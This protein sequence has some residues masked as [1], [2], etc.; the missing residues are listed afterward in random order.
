NHCRAN[1]LRGMLFSVTSGKGFGQSRIITASSYGVYMDLTFDV[2]FSEALDA[3][4]VWNIQ[5]SRLPSLDATLRPSVL[6]SN[7]AVLDATAI[8]T[9]AAIW[10]AATRTLTRPN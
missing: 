9:A 3:T 2:A 10:S 1:A 4:T 5:P 6:D 8:P 7:G